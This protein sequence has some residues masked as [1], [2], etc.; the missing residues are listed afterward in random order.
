MGRKIVAL[1]DC[2]PL[3]LSG[4][5]RDAQDE[6]YWGVNE[7]LQHSKLQVSGGDWRLFFG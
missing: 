2:L 6:G 3:G 5:S 7:I 4:M 1:G